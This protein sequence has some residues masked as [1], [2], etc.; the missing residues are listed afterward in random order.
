MK[1][2][3]KDE[4]K[5]MTLAISDDLSALLHMN[6]SL[7][8]L[9]LFSGEFRSYLEKAKQF[10]YIGIIETEEPKSRFIVII[11]A[12]LI[13]SLSNILL[14]GNGSI[15]DKEFE[16]FTFS[17][18][19]AGDEILE[20]FLFFQKSLEKDCKLLRVENDIDLVHSFYYDEPIYQVSMTCRVRGEEIGSIDLCYPQ[21]VYG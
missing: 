14:G 16:Y 2:E 5:K 8:N 9:Q 10:A 17:E 3:F 1:A 15:E 20:R 12:D 18:T 4:H 19:F 13:Y 7:E 11:A 6:V 21:S